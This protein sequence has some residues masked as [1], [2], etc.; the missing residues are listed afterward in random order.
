[1]VFSNCRDRC[2]TTGLFLHTLVSGLPEALLGDRFAADRGCGSC[3]GLDCS[4]LLQSHCELRLLGPM[5]LF[6]QKVGLLI[7]ELV[8]GG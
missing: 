4:D 3:L 5:G 1:M 7:E 8:Q 2:S 6:P